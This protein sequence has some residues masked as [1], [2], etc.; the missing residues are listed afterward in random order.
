MRRLCLLALIVAGTSLAATPRNDKNTTTNTRYV[1]SAAERA[2]GEFKEADVALPPVPDAGG[3]GW[4]DLYVGNGFDKQP[5]ILLDSIALAPDGSVRY[6]LNIRS[7]KGYDNLSTEGFLCSDTSLSLNEAKRSAY[8]IFGYADT[9]NRRWIS[10][11]NSEWKPIG[12]IL[13]TADT[14]RTVLYRAFCVDGRPDSNAALQQRVRER[15]GRYAKS[16][17]NPGK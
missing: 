6:V 4:F 17:G 11:R 2:S 1:E 12:S 10:A 9:V 15:S 5:R 7:A 16:L 8:K 14:V 13:N 3:E